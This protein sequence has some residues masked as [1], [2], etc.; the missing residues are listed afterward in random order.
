MARKGRMVASY[1]L[2]L[3]LWLFELRQ[4]RAHDSTLG[5]SRRSRNPPIDHAATCCLRLSLVRGTVRLSKWLDL[6]RSPSLHMRSFTGPDPTGPWPSLG[7]ACPCVCSDVC[8]YIVDLL[9]ASATGS[10]SYGHCEEQSVVEL[11]H[12][13]ESTFQSTGTRE[14]T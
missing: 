8:K 6:R 9:G 1:L 4:Q 2:E 7:Y 11:E 13:L 10:L 3:T 5:T 12:D 14:R